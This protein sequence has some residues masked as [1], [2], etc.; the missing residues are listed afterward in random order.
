M[1][2]YGLEVCSSFVNAESAQ[3]AN[4]L[5]SIGIPGSGKSVIASTLIHHLAR[6]G[7]PVLYFYFR[8]TID[9]NHSPVSL[10]RDWLVQILSFIPL[11]QVQLKKY[12]DGRRS[13]ESLKITE[14]WGDLRTALSCLPK[15]YCVVDALDEMDLGGDIEAFILSLAELG[16]WQP[17]RIKLI[18]TSRPMAAV[19][20]PLKSKKMIHIR[21]D[22][23]V[24][25]DDI[26]FYVRNRLAASAIVVEDHA[27]I[28]NAVSGK[29]NGLFLYAKLAM[30]A[31][32]EPGADV[33]KV[34]KEL[35]ADLNAI[36]TGVL[37]D[38]VRRSG[39]P[40]HLQLLI[41]ELVIH[42]TQPLRLLELADVVN[43]TQL[44][45][46]EQNI[47]ATKHL[48][49][50]ACGPLL[51]ILPDETVCVIHHS[52]TEF[53][54]G[55]TRQLTSHDYPILSL[56]STHNHLALVCLGYLHPEVSMHLK[57]S[58]L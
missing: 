1:G 22:E 56:G 12:M 52:L 6:E 55:T 30:D 49:R 28:K 44:S 15:V 35:P 51:E 24:V 32:L 23:N 47:K 27:P 19:E 33:S 18:I 53:L 41:L 5:V 8:Q 14:L 11:L 2:C 29:A 10:L 20:R 34:L 57:G 37:L 3:K 38:H 43:V 9:A 42:A 4:L 48:V 58:K 13:L 21:L 16:Q 50:S 39:I 17:S 36:Y 40:D 26:A 45:G 46:H 54:N 25:N 31:F 7:V